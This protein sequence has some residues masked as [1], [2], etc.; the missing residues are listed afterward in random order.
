MRRR[1]S[2]VG[3][4][5]NLRADCQ[6]ERVNNPPQDGILPHSQTDPRLDGG[7]SLGF[8][9]MSGVGDHS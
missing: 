9:I 6:S 1:V 5:A 3:Q 2:L 8:R 4:I 7:S